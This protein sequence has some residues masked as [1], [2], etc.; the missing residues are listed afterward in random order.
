M[1][2]NVQFVDLNSVTK[3]AAI[4]IVSSRVKQKTAD[5]VRS[6]ARTVSY[7]GFRPGKVPLQMVEKIEGPR[8]RL[9]AIEALID[10]EI[11]GIVTENKFEISGYP[12]V[13][14]KSIDEDKDVAVKVTFFLYPNPE[15]KSYDS[16]EVAV[17][18]RS[19]SDADVDAALE[20]LRESRQHVHAIKDRTVAAEGDIVVGTVTVQIDGGE[21]SKSE[22]LVRPLDRNKDNPEL[23]AGL[24]GKE[25]GKEHVIDTVIPQDHP[26]EAQRGKNRTYR[27]TI[28][29]LYE[30]HLP[31]VDDQFAESL[32]FGVKTVEELRQKLRE[33]LEQNHEQGKKEEVREGIVERL[34]SDHEFE[35]P[36]NL[37]DNEIRVM[38][39]QSGA[40]QAS[41]M[42]AE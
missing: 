19:V 2:S 25:L 13:E 36:Q 42:T 7:K 17:T 30:K 26:V 8:L 28:N 33:R 15:L 10:E 3:E 11:G 23:V 4:T 35:V 29:E 34:L 32:P 27:V 14:V 38:L 5:A 18:E 31:T 22:P 16:I 6:R 20:S 40:Q 1:S 37:V 41:S 24:I 9:E 39:N 21:P 12:A